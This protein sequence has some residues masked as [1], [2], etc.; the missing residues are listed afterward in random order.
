[1]RT[2]T[3][4]QMAEAL[5]KAKP[6]LSAAYYARQIR[7]WA[8]ADLFPDAGIRGSGRTAAQIFQRHHLVMSQVYGF[9]TVLG[10]TAP[11]LKAVNACFRNGFDIRAVVDAYDG[12]D[13][14]WRFVLYLNEDGDVHG[15]KFTK[16]VDINPLAQAVAPN[17][18]FLTQSSIFRVLD[19]EQIEGA[20]SSE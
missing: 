6:S 2:Y 17:V 14:D 19:V 12:G 8:Q 5:A 15:G 4:G 1:M 10:M 3:V 18:L 11:Q 9:L 13:R 16:H 20:P 7:G